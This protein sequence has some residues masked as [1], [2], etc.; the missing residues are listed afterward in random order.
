MQRRAGCACLEIGV[1]QQVAQ[2]LSRQ[3]FPQQVGWLRGRLQLH[4]G[5]AVQLRQGRLVRVRVRG[6]VR[7]LVPGLRRLCSCHLYTHQGSGF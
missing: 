7:G 6:Q 2:G 4:V 3:I 5:R 1:Q